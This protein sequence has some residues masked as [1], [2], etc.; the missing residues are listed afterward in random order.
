MGRQPTRQLTWEYVLRTFKRVRMMT[1]LDQGLLAKRFAD[2]PKA[3]VQVDVRGVCEWMD[4]L[5]NE[6]D[7]A[8]YTSNVA[9]VAGR[10]HDNCAV[11]GKEVM[12]DHNGAKYCSTE[13]RQRA[14]RERKAQAQGRNSPLPKRPRAKPQ[15]Q[16]PAEVRALQ[17]AQQLANLAYTIF[18][19]AYALEETSRSEQSDTSNAAP[20]ETNVTRPSLNAAFGAWMAAAERE[21][22]EGS[23]GPPPHWQDDCR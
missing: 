2:D 14:Y 7:K 6:L 19:K 11:C 23:E 5:L 15:I 10:R 18:K 16:L 20:D 9:N 21:R 8:G 3:A 22:G 4:S 13:C 12:Q 17:D 1:R